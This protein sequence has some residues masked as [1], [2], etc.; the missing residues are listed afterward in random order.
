[1]NTGKIYVV[2]IG[3]GN[4]AGMTP[5]A[6]EAISRADAIVGYGLY[7]ELISRLTPGKEVFSSGMRHEAERCEAALDFAKSGRTAAL[8]C[9][10][11]AGVYGM[12]GVMLEVARGCPEVEIEIVP[13]VTAACA[14]AAV[15]GAPLMHDFAV[16]SLSDLLTP[17][18]II[19][20]RL[21]AACAA[22]FVICLYNPKSANRAEQF[23]RAA[24]IM[25]E[26]KDAQT[27]CGVVRNAGREGRASAICALSE[28]D[29]QNV[30]MFCTVIAGNSQ[31]R[32]IN[33]RMVTPRG[34]D[35]T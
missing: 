25:L 32:V 26:Y 11:D 2:G 5:Q 13:G 15:L 17:W 31:T 29:K 24:R 22:D 7:I 33:G 12:A 14:A 6:L 19:E 1:M 27:P 8:V 28:L 21:R 10:G 34:Y 3:P 4:D 16:I 35:I 23:G 18:D 9:G 30:D 20:K